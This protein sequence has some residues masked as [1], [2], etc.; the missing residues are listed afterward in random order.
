[1]SLEILT[2][3]CLE[4]NYAFI[5]RCTDT[6]ETA[7]VDA[8]ES[9][10]ILAALDAKGW[11][12][13][14]ILITHHHSDHIDGVEA[15]RGATG[16]MVYGGA[17]DA[18]RLPPLDYGLAEGDSV[19]V[20]AH[21]GEV[22][23]VSGHTIGHIAF[24]FKQAKAAFS[25]DSLM[26]LGCGRVFEGTQAQQ[27]VTLKKF[28]E[29]PA[30]TMIYSG[31]EYTAAN[32]AFAVTIEPDNAD[33]Q[34]RVKDIAEARGRGEATV[35]SLLSLELATNPFL[36]AGVAGVKANMGMASASD[37]D[38]FCAIRTRKDDF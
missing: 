21:K 28:M 9:A 7:L 15:I 1:M 8:P 14:K 12:L 34:A 10:P 35:P 24:L 26:A 16:A 27:W 29:L 6:G 3:P 38:V 37:S 17:A 2:L 23:D 30:D 33:L 25:A 32:G 18:H 36:R 31:H 4:D 19:T 22:I 11:P 5:L 20:G 13:H